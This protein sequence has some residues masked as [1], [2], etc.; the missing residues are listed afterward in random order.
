MSAKT[1]YRLLDVHKSYKVGDV[2]VDALR[3]LSLELA[4]GEFVALQG[5]SG[6]GKSTLL[7]ILGLLET[8]TSGGIE[9]HGKRLES[10][11]EGEL[12]DI[13]QNYIGFIFQNF[14]LI[15]V[16]SALENVEYALYLEQRWSKRDIRERAMTWL[17]SVGL[18]K[19]ADHKPRELSGGQRQ[20]VAIAR[21]LVKRPQLIIADEPTANLDTK[22]A[23]QILELIGELKTKSRTTVLVATHDKATADRAE[24][25][26]KIRDGQ[27]DP[28]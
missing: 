20:R 12:T 11:G 7:N 22:T 4:E 6:S 5:P 16:L 14:N 24:R 15:P 13:R 1:L 10:C 17:I 9:F 18:E 23:A 3:G 28:N 19:F 8:P 2:V 21:A 26:V 25:I 27:L